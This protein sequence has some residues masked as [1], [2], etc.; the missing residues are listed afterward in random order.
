M[1]NEQIIEQ[2]N[3][4]REAF[5]NQTVRSKVVEFNGMQAEIRQPSV[6]EILN[7]QVS[8]EGAKQDVMLDIIINRCYVPGTD[9]KIFEEGDKTALK[10]LPFNSAFSTLLEAINELIDAEKAEEEAVKK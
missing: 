1:S 10:E 6:A 8:E 9:V 4:I 3:K 7:T 5:L 2:R